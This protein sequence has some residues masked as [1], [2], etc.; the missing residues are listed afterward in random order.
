MTWLAVISNGP[1][2][3]T[4]APR[5]LE[6]HPQIVVTVNHLAADYPCDYWVMSDWWPFTNTTP[7][8]RDGR[9]PTIFGRRAWVREMDAPHVGRW[10]AWPQMYLEDIAPAMPAPDSPDLPLQRHRHG[11]SL[12]LAAWDGFSGRAALGVAYWLC[13]REQCDRAGC[14]ALDVVLC[15]YDMAGGGGAHDEDAGRAN[16]TDRRWVEER[17]IF[18]W[19]L[20]AFQSAGISVAKLD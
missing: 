4:T 12:G 5:V 20:R 14:R 19:F 15:G 17:L 13:R 18:E 11:T 1:S 6:G 16:R 9:Q 2:A 3:R 7:L 10:Q 8:P